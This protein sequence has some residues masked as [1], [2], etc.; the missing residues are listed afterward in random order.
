MDPNFYPFATLGAPEIGSSSRLR[1][2]QEEQRQLQLTAGGRGNRH[3]LGDDL[4]GDD[5][6]DVHGHIGNHAH[7]HHGSTSGSSATTAHLGNDDALSHEDLIRAAAVQYK[8]QIDRQFMST[9]E[10][11]LSRGGGRGRITNGRQRLGGLMRGRQAGH[12]SDDDD[13]DDDN[14]PRGACSG[15]SAATVVVNLVLLGIIASYHA[16]IRTM[17]GVV[18]DATVGGAQPPAG[19]GGGGEL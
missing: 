12:D 11:A 15:L 16:L 19:Q 1:R 10:E 3:R 5:G 4:F 7:H 6:S 2:R 14:E 8:R 17:W 13:D 18:V 9:P